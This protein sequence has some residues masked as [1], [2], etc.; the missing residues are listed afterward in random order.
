MR[1]DVVSRT[2][3]NQSLAFSHAVTLLKDGAAVNTTRTSGG[4]E[5][6]SLNPDVQHAMTFTYTEILDTSSSGATTTY[7]LQAQH[8]GGGL[9]VFESPAQTVFQTKVFT[10]HNIGES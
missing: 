2:Q 10:F 8:D 6:S 5:V 9:N 4:T 3:A 7:Q 1:C